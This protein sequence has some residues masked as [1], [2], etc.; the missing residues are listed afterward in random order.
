MRAD[1][2]ALPG[3]FHQL[4]RIDDA[5]RWYWYQRLSPFAGGCFSF[6]AITRRLRD[7]RYRQ[8]DAPTPESPLPLCGMCRE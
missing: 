8:S 2:G 5:T 6:P 3:V 7:Y 1:S 4:I